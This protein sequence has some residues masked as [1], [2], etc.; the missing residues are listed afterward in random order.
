MSS[1]EVE[2]LPPILEVSDIQRYLKIGKNQAYD[3]C[4]SGQFHVVRVGRLIKVKREVFLMWLEGSK[5]EN[6]G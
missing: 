6:Q 5:Q 2:E 1:L 4:N 3:L